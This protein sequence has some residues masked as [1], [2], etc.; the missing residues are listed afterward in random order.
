MIS[1]HCNHT[2]QEGTRSSATCSW[3][4]H[5]SA[6]HSWEPHSWA[7]CSS[8]QAVQAARSRN[9][10]INHY[11]YYYYYHYCDQIM[12]IIA[13]TII[14]IVAATASIILIMNENKYMY[15]ER[16]GYRYMNLYK[17]VRYENMFIHVFLS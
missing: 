10:T 13:S 2:S 12:A 15:I 16:D 4:T 9:I 6:T 3:A 17:H 14:V 1:R 5:S 7:T 11:N 8:E